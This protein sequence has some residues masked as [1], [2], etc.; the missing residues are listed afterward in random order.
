[1]TRIGQS[2]R[3]DGIMT[4]LTDDGFHSEALHESYGDCDALDGMAF[5]I[6]KQGI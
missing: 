6:T 4:F 5:I 2:I 3:T 1:M